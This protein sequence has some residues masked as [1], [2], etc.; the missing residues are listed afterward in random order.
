M[1]T[2][3]QRVGVRHS[4]RRSCESDLRHRDHEISALGN[5]TDERFLRWH[6]GVGS[7]VS[8]RFSDKFSV[9]EVAIF[10]RCENNLGGSNF[11]AAKIPSPS[12]AFRR[13]QHKEETPA[14]LRSFRPL[15]RGRTF[16]SAKSS[17]TPRS[18][19]LALREHKSPHSKARRYPVT[20]VP[21]ASPITTPSLHREYNFFIDI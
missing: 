8:E 12:E 1:A 15:L 17:T 6:L 3:G 13:W 20:T 10:A 14:L 18:E 7:G 4:Q 16:R 2:R 21:T 5:A 11:R 9:L 19:V